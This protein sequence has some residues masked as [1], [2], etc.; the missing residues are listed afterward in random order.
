MLPQVPVPALS[1]HVKDCE[2]KTA[3]KSCY[4][5]VLVSYTCFPTRTAAVHFA[6]GSLPGCLE[7][8]YAEANGWYN[9][10]RLSLK[11]HSKSLLCA[12]ATCKFL[13]THELGNIT[14]KVG[15]KGRR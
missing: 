4:V 15:Q 1:R 6:E 3:Q 2:R 12:R 14:V 7:L 8:L 5:S 11:D 9:V 13:C 10:L